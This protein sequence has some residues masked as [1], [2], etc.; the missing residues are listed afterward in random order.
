MIFI[1]NV[2]YAGEEKARRVCVTRSGESADRRATIEAVRGDVE[3]VNVYHYDGRERE[4]LVYKR[5]GTA[6]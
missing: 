2:K 1:V 6:S 5:R 4:I 3:A